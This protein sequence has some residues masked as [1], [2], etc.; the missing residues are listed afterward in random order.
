[1]EVGAGEDNIA[2]KAAKNSGNLDAQGLPIEGHCQYRNKLVAGLAMAAMMLTHKNKRQLID[3]A[4]NRYANNDDEMPEWFEKEEAPH[5]V[6]GIP[7]TKEMADEVKVAN[8][9][10]ALLSNRSCSNASAR[11]TRGRSR[12]CWRRRAAST[13]RSEPQGCSAATHC[14]ADGAQAGEAQAAR[15]RHPGK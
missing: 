4:Y 2:A 8:R 11:L 15:E 12:R 9:I 13:A 1:M 5:R 7:M 14:G 10:C 3:D 6:R